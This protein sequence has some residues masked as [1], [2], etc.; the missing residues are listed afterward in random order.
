[1][2]QDCRYQMPGFQYSGAPA[3]RRRPGKLQGCEPLQAMIEPPA[4]HPIEREAV[5][6]AG[7]AIG[8]KELA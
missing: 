1:M 3:D 7:A 5:D 8:G 6:H 2:S 4:L